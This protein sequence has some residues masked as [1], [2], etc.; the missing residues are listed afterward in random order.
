MAS[1]EELETA[2]RTGQ[3]ALT[4]ATVRD[5]SRLWPVLNVTRPSDRSYGAWQAAMQA[6]VA[7]NGDAASTL[8]R[9]YVQAA[10]DLAEQDGSPTLVTAAPAATQQVETSLRVTS[11]V[12]YR[13]GLAA[14][15]SQEEAARSALIQASGAASRLVANAGR[16]TVAESTTASRG[17]WT[18]VTSG[19][20][21][22]FCKMIA[23]RGAVYRR[24]VNF[25][26]HDHC[27]C[28]L[29]SEFGTDL[30]S[31][32]STPSARR[33]TDADRARVRA[34]LRANPATA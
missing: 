15:L 14:G 18:R 20:A 19:G 17:R 28:S 3:V 30:P 2:Y 4:A 6:L 21:C 24:G 32:S 31:V 34:W 25:A 5:A 12:A 23:G 11:L 1:S 16:S 13:R 29:R 7:R 9:S 10:W 26:S 8:G 27:N 22:A 33:A